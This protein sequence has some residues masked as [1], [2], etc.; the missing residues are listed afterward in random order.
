LNIELHTPEVFS[1]LWE[2]KA[3]YKGA[4]GGRGSGKSRDRA[5][6][7]VIAMLKGERVVGVREVQLSIRDSVKQL[8]EDEIERM[9]LLDQFDIVRDEIRCAG[10]GNMIFRGL[11]DYSAESI[12]SLEGYTRCWVE[13]A[14]TISERSL[15]LL[16]PT[17]REPGSEFW[18]TWNPRYDHDPVDHLLRGPHPPDGAVVVN[19]NWPDNPYF[20]EDLR[21]DMERDQRLDPVLYEHIWMGGY[22]HIGEGAYYATQL[23][24]ARLDD[25]VTRVPVE[26]GVLVHTAWDIGIDDCTAIWA[27]QRVG[28]E[29]HVVD[30]VEDRGHDASYYAKWVRDNGYDTGIALLPHDAGHREKG[31]GRT[32]EEHLNIA[33]L[34]RTQVLPQTSSLMTDIDGV[35]RFIPLCWFDQDRCADGLKA[36]GAYRTEMDYKSRTPKLQPVHDWS[37]HG[38]DSF[39]ALSRILTYT[40]NAE[41]YDYADVRINVRQSVPSHVGG[42]TTLGPR[43]GS[44]MGRRVA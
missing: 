30:Y 29:V 4:W 41:S 10:G 26:P 32:Y 38:A 20:P 9:E 28:R 7:C 40:G 8:V 35:R 15:R 34:R 36:L 5:T 25:R 3:R 6:A 2:R 1:P 18:F 12:K 33:G 37:S 16:L 24:Q 42:G 14:Q 23:S 22:Q 11:K 13:E 27:A 21:A 19:A 17:I 43:G 31:T 44:R 39:R